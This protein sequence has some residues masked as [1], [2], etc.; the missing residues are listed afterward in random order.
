MRIFL[1]CL[2]FVLLIACNARKEQEEEQAWHTL[3]LGAF[4]LTTPPGWSSFKERGIDSYVGGITNGKDSMWFDLGWYS[5][6]IDGEDFGKHLYAQDTI[7]G[8]IAVIELPKVDGKGSVRLSI[9]RVND[10]DKFNL[11]GYNIKD[12]KTILKIFKSVVFE[13]SDTT[14]N[15]KLNLEQFKSF[16]QGSGAA[17]YSTACRN[18]HHR[19]RDLTGPALTPAL[20]ESRSA[21]WLSRFFSDR[22]S[23]LQDSA[24]QSRIREFGLQ[25]LELNGIPENEVEMLVS[26]IKG[27]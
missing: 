3:D 26:Y 20:L 2:T 22:K 10:K 25:C 14:I 4:K 21:E 11:G 23:V 12:S 1:T 27:L 8:L 19:Y 5:A 9:P 7:N 15:G 18:C 24:C 6:E 17:L 13:E 16:D